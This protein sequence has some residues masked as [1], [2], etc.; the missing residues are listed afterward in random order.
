MNWRNAAIGLAAG[1]PVAAGGPALVENGEPAVP[2]PSAPPSDHPTVSVVASIAARART[3]GTDRSVATS[4]TISSGPTP[5]SA[6]T[7]MAT[8]RHTTGT[9]AA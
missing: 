3:S 6:R 8:P 1:V 9:P 7:I 4:M 2:R 5:M